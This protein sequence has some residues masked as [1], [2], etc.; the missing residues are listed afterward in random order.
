MYSSI[1]RAPSPAPYYGAPSGRP[2]DG[3]S[4]YGTPVPV[5]PLSRAASPIPMP[6]RPIS[7][8][9]S[10]VPPGVSDFQ[11]EKAP[12]SPGPYGRPG[13]PQPDVYNRDELIYRQQVSAL[14]AAK[15]RQIA[16]TGRIPAG[17]TPLVLFF[18]TKVSI[19]YFSRYIALLIRDHQCRMG[20]RTLLISQSI[21]GIPAPHL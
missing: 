20:C 10:P 18:R 11:I 4:Y 3:Q 14:I 6:V 15:D 13:M 1:N 16:A 9:S 7:R 19:L 2:S 21:R 5:R 12:K 8:A 17:P